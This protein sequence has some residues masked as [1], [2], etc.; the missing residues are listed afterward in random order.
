MTQAIK[1]KVVVI[2]GASSGLG[3]AT[4]RQLARHG[5]KL[6]LGA[7]RLDR[8]Q[9]LAEEL[10]LGS[11]AAVQTDVTQYAQV[12]H[13]V[14]HA[15]Q[16][17]GRI[18]V[19]IN[20]AGLMPQSP[21]ER[22]KVEDWDPTIDVN[23][24]GTLY[25]IAAALPHMKV[26]QS[27]HI[28]NVSSVAGHKVGPGGAVYAATKTAVRVLS[29]GLRQEVKPYHIRTTVISPGSVATEL[30][31]CITEPDIAEN[32]RQRYKIA[33]PADSFANMVVFAMSQPEEVDV[34]EI[35]FRPT[36]Q[37]F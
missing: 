10:S 29:E 35:L 2:T 4:A 11:E 34:N 32:Y 14:D 16:V 15:A 8:L 13:L 25:G 1:E 17:H 12:K 24:K 22:A 3:E 21:L 33:L 6:V 37:E 9:A 36:R 19:I 5:A 28:I 30:L 23:L 18:D 20:N 27:G 7:R 31:E 26:Q